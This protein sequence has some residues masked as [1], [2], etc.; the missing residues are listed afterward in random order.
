MQE[1]MGENEFIIS[2][3]MLKYFDVLYED[4]EVIT[5]T[6]KHHWL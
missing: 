1:A 4:A 3:E 5:P 6:M 2:V